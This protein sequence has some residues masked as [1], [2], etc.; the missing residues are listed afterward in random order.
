MYPLVQVKL[1]K[2][3]LNFYLHSLSPEDKRKIELGMEM[4]QFGMKN[5]LVSYRNKYFIYK[6]TAKGDDLTVE[7]VALA[8][9]GYKLAFL[10]NLVASY[11]FEMIGAKFIEARYKGIYR[12]NDLTV[13]VEKWKKVRIARWLEDFQSWVTEL[14]DSDYLQ[15]TTEIWNPS[16]KTKFTMEEEEEWGRISKTTKNWSRNTQVNGFLY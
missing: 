10:A 4:V 1:I 9:R 6:G 3:A 5:T 12:D 13:L 16:N 11:L 7:D 8:I 14:T 15:F 2:K